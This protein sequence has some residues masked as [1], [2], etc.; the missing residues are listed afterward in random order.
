MASELNIVVL[1]GGRSGEHDVSR[2][3]AAYIIETLQQCPEYKVL[4]VGITRE[5]KWYAYSGPVTA[6]R[7]GNWLEQ[8]PVSPAILTPDASGHFLYTRRKSRTV[9]YPADCVFPVLH[10]RNGEDGTIQGMLEMAGIPFVGCGMTACALAMDKSFANTIFESRQLPHTPWR[11][12][13]RASWIQEG[14]PLL[15][16]LIKGLAYPLFVK[17]ARAGSSLGI[18]R[19]LERQDLPAAIDR[20]LIHD[21]KVIIEEAVKGRELEIA[22]LGG[23]E[24]PVLSPVGEIVPDRDFYDYDSKYEEGSASELI[25]PAR[26]TD[27][28][29]AAL[30]KIAVGAWQALECYGM[31]RIDFFLSDDGR[32]LLNEINTIPGF[33]SISMYPRLFRAAGYGDAQLLR[34]LIRLALARGDEMG[35][36]V[37]I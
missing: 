25:I 22:A 9:S 11:S 33:V 5:G 34:E 1:F 7:E 12:L 29:E 37:V 21:R 2:S 19:V 6:L 16:G 36:G 14:S 28:E 32:V 8:G 24:E 35:D 15:D 23:Y 18:T 17:P 4:P 3:S 20:A 13:D 10:G 26:L 31:A 30:R 27:R